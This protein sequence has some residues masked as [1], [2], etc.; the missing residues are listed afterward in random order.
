VVRAFVRAS[1]V[2]SELFQLTFRSSD[3]PTF[4]PSDVLPA[5]KSA[6]AAE[7]FLQLIQD[8]APTLRMLGRRHSIRQIGVVNRKSVSP[9][10]AASRSSVTTDRVL[11][12]PNENHVNESLCGRS[13]T[14][15][16]PVCSHVPCGAIMSI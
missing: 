6:C 13:T 14:K 5:T 8:L 4:R 11:F 9:S 10:P 15:Y 16:S 7:L 12:V 1:S 2:L 3:L